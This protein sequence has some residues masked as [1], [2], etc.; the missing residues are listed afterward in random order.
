MPNKVEQIL[1]VDR[2][3]TKTQLRLFLGT[4][5]YYR[6]FVPNYSATAVALTDATA[7][8]R[9]NELLWSEAMDDAFHK[10]KLCLST[11]PILQLPDWSKP[12]V[13]GTDASDKG[14][15]AV[16][17]QDHDNV[18]EAIVVYKQKTVAPREA[19]VDDR[20]RVFGN[21]LGSRKIPSLFIRWRV[22]AAVWP[23]SIGIYGQSPVSKR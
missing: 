19:L 7:K 14:I 22:R 10:L 8:S 12:F 4:A 11:A 2:P 18:S 6:S 21:S 23:P 5:G 13:L 1:K 17:L 15:G 9:P 20:A 16:L 3:K